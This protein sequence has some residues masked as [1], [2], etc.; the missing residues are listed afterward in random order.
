LANVWAG[1]GFC[2]SGMPFGFMV[3]YYLAQSAVEQ[4][5]AREIAPLSYQRPT[6]APY[7]PQ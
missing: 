7:R 3:G 6:L 4:K 2:G 5:T 1:G